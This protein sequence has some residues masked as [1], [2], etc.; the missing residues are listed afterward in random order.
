MTMAPHVAIYAERIIDLMSDGRERIASE[1]ADSVGATPTLA[2]HVMTQLRRGGYA[3]STTVKGLH[4]W[5]MDRRET[6]E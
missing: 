5:R 6:P 1:I 2:G 4:I 3:T